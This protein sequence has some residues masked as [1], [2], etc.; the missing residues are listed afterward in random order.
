MAVV[1]CE[2]RIVRSEAVFKLR[3]AVLSQTAARIVVLDLSEVD[4]VGG[5]GLGMLVFLQ[6]WAYAQDIRL[7]VFNP[8][9]SVRDRLGYAGSTPAF[10]IATHDEMIALLAR[11]ASRYA[12]AS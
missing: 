10:E 2:G 3:D 9:R 11:A 4:V 5:A 7:R 6:R 1:E 8:C 12:F